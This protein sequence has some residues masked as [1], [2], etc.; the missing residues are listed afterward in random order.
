MDNASEQMNRH[1]KGSRRCGG[2]SDKIRRE[3]LEDEDDGDRQ[4]KRPRLRGNHD[5]DR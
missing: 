2:G 4:Y 1:G 3:K 5:D